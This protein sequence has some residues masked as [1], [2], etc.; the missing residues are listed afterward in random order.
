MDFI[1]HQMDSNFA[2]HSNKQKQITFQLF[3]NKNAHIIPSIIDFLKS[4][5]TIFLSRFHSYAGKSL[6]VLNERRKKIADLARE[7]VPTVYLL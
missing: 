4:A 7:E 2:I 5:S 6:D 3:E 1:F